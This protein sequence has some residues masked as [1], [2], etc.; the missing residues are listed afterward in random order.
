MENAFVF[1]FFAIRKTVTDKNE[2][3]EKFSFREDRNENFL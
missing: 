3:F 1:D 2:L